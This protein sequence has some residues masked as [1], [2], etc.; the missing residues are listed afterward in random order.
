MLAEAL[1]RIRE[2]IGDQAKTEQVIQIIQAAEQEERETRTQRQMN[3]IEAARQRGVQFGRPQMDYPRNFAK[4]CLKQ[5]DGLLTV[6]EASQLLN[7]SRQQF[8][9]LRSRYEEQQKAKHK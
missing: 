5:R 7:V 9:R 4:I 8:Y 1:D 6:S 3:G 2:I